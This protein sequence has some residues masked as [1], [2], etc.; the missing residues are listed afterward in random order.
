MPSTGKTTSFR[1]LGPETVLYN[2]EKKMLPFKNKGIRMAT[3]SSVDELISKLKKFA[4]PKWG[5]SIE[6]IIVDSFSDFA[7]MLMAEC[8]MK[9]K[10]FDVFNA[11]N[12]KIYE[13]FQALKTLEGK[14]VFLTGHPETLQDADGNVIYRMSV[15]GKEWEGRV[16]KVAT[17]VL[18]ADPQRKANGKGVEY[19]FLT[20]TDGRYPAKTPMEMFKTMHI[21][22]DVAEIV[23]VYKSFYAQEAPLMNAVVAA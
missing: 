23:K 13:F 7:D 5:A 8:R 21:G 2:T 4:D 22:N 17:C 9:H 6:N 10:G 15:K 18:Y 12:G 3:A 1:N 19:R 20:N 14:Y 16:E 11:Y